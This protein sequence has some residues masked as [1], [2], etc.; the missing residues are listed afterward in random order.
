MNRCHAPFSQPPYRRRKL[1]GLWAAPLLFLVTQVSAQVTVR[2]FPPTAERAA[3]VVTAPPLIALNGKPDRLSP[4]SRI[5]GQ[6]NLLQMSGSLIGQTLLV[7][8]VRSPSGEV[9]EVWIL[10]E[11]EAALK[12]PT[13]P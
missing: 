2:P 5:R 12:L 8:F 3:M 6:N 9:Q 4:G 11:G 13:Q 10:T 7:N 1:L